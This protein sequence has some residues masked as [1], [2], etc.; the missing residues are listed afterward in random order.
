MG[1]FIDRFGTFVIPFL[2]LF[3]NHKGASDAVAGWAVGLL[4]VGGLSAAFVG[5]YLADWLG[6]RNTICLSMVGSAVCGLLLFVSVE[7]SHALGGLWLMFFL[8]VLYGL[9]RGL[10]FPASSSL[11]AD[12]VPNDSRVAAFSILRFAINLGWALGMMAAG[13]LAEISFL[14]LFLIDSLTSF[15]YGII[16]V[17]LL[18]HGIRTER[19]L[20]Q[21]GPALQVI[22]RD[23]RFLVVCVNSLI[24][25][26]IYT[27]WSSSYARLLQDHMP[28]AHPE[29][30]FGFI[31]AINGFMIA[32]L[33]I[34]ISAVVRRFSAP[35]MIAL[36][37]VF[38]AVG[39]AMNG[40]VSGL[41]GLV[42]A[43]V[44]F[45]IGEMISM[46]VQGAYVSRL[47][48]EKMRGRYNGMLGLTWSSATILAPG[49]GLWLLGIGPGI[50]CVVM[51]VLGLSSAGVLFLA[52][53]VGL[54]PVAS[55]LESS[56][57]G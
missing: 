57:D 25:A 20:S 19:K 39:F 40:W 49:M 55:P 51:L 41:V 4:G 48:P 9:V 23:A 11:I 10:Y 22:S 35:R 14:L 3:L 27:Q 7:F 29:R 8:A 44:V 42:T 24:V 38:A 52:S 5:G 17:K 36:G 53:N 37:S 13:F 32:L 33:E 26:M 6:R 18:P 2:V 43:M 47:A 1:I 46:P 28:I 34:P 45:T 30:T 16:A 54:H 15:T 50:L 21:W 31:M 12:L 56:S